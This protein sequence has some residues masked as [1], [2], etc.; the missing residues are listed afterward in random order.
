MIRHL[1]IVAFS[2]ATAVSLTACLDD[3]EEAWGDCSIA[4][5][6][7]FVYELMHDFYYWYRL[8]PDLDP[9]LLGSPEET[10][11]ALRFAP[12]DRYSYIADAEE[13]ERFLGEGEYIGVGIST[14]IGEDGYPVVTLVFDDSPAEEAKIGRGDRL[15]TIN[16]QPADGLETAEAW[17]A[18]WGEKEVG[19]AVTLELQ[20]LGESEPVTL[21]LFK[22]VVT[23]N[24]VYHHA[25]LQLDGGEPAGYLHYTHFLGVGETE[26]DEV[27]EGFRD[28][29]VRKVILDL[30]YNGGGYLDT[31][32]HLANLVAGAE[33]EDEL[34]VSLRY[35]DRYTSYD[36]DYLFRK[37]ES[38]LPR[39]DE[40]VVLVTDATCSAAEALVNGLDPFVPVTLVGSTTCGKP[41]GFNGQ[42]F[43]DRIAL[44]VNFELR[45]ALD[46]G[47]YYDGLPVLCPAED[48][49]THPLGDTREGMLATAIGWLE[50]GSCPATTLAHL[51]SRPPPRTGLAAVIGAE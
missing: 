30:R 51:A 12:L 15:L 48:D 47:E 38:G 4:G 3:D 19:E 21:T 41:V 23:I 44:V 40:A 37:L 31:S 13:Q 29:G 20:P 28:A 1:L 17:A 2:A 18:A 42:L 50:S 36:Y 16:G 33:A 26:L 10:L 25:I 7:T 46:E 27:F 35:N 14:R 24:S 34:Y 8:V 32:A 45:N 9:T 39:V 43:C 49:T 11:E 6:N 5:Q 22:A